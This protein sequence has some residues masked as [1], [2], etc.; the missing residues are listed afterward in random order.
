M[1]S[2]MDT[3]TRLGVVAVRTASIAHQTAHMRQ[4][5]WTVRMAL[6]TAITALDIYLPPSFT[7][8]CEAATFSSV[9]RGVAFSSLRQMFVCIRRLMVSFQLA[10]IA[11]RILYKYVLLI[12]S[13][14]NFSDE[15]TQLKLQVSY[16]TSI[17]VQWDYGI[18]VRA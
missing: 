3:G 6:R 9:Y 7:F 14:S 1:N 4:T 12:W 17:C 18:S 2:G 5:D 10:S 15:C 13:C 8:H 16:I 11:I